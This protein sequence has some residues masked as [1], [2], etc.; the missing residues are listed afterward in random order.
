MSIDYHQRI[1]QAIASPQGL[2]KL[3]ANLPSRIKECRD[4]MGLQR[5]LFYGLVVATILV[6]GPA[7]AEPVSTKAPAYAKTLKPQIEALI[8]HLILN[9]AYRI[10]SC[11]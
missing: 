1:C 9:F 4:K 3:V 6:S 5:H 2:G 11:S 10:Q 7:A 8:H